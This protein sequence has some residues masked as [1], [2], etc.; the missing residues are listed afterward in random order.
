MSV[1][2]L[3]LFWSLVLFYLIPNLYLVLRVHFFG[4]IPSDL[5]INIVSQLSWINLLYEVV[6]EA[7]LL[8]LYFLIG[9]SIHNPTEFR[10]K[11]CSGYVVITL[12]YSTFSIII[13]IF[14]EP[15]CNIM[16]QK[17]ELI[18]ISVDYIR[19][20]TVASIFATILK[21]SLLLLVLLDKAPF[22]YLLVALQV[23]LTMFFD[24]FFIS[25]FS[26]SMNL[27]VNGVAIS[28]I[29]ANAIT[30][31]GTIFYITKQFKL[32]F[33]NLSYGWLK[34]WIN[35]GKYSGLES[36]VRNLSFSLMIIRMVNLTHEQGNYWIANNFIWG[37]LL[38]P[39]LALSDLIKREASEDFN[40]MR[41]LMPSYIKISFFIIGFWLLSMPLW[42]F[43]IKNIMN[44]QDFKTVLWLVH[45]QLPFYMVFTFTC[46]LTA[47]LYGRG[48]TKYLF[49]RS[50]FIDV[51]YY[52][53]VFILY[54]NKVF[55]PSLKTISIIFG[56][57]IILS[58]IPTI[59]FYRRTVNQR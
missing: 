15:L 27:G 8:P 39:V 42:Q 13:S 21:Y 22:I 48:K 1:L 17:P 38:V 7:L 10:N 18:A 37:F 28:N 16:A 53:L 54:M 14:A 29:L 11:A 24:T 40:N 4:D 51:F 46:I 2:N 31:S 30:L 36:L 9:K 45:I 25:Q 59:Y 47:V 43:L 6:H 12:I 58:N 55:T 35:I 20:E 26:F 33:K 23:C 34:E 57:G 3:R 44:V 5:G 50:I 32:S 56:C 41:K 19:L 49:Y 52:G